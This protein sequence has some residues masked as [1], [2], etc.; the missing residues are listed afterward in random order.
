MKRTGISMRS[1][2]CSTCWVKQKHSVLWKN[3]AAFDGATLGMAW[4]VI[5]RSVGLWATNSIWLLAPGCTLSS[6]CCG[7]KLQTM[8]AALVA[9]NCTRTVRASSTCWLPLYA[10]EVLPLMP[11]AWHITS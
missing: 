1:P 11:K 8:P 2:G 4:A 9:R 7:A 5:G 3:A 10:P 6:S